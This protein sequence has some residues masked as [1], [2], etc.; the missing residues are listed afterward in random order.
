MCMQEDYLDRHVHLVN[1]RIHV[2]ASMINTVLFPACQAWMSNYIQRHKFA[3]QVQ[4]CLSCAIIL[5]LH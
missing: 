4:L 3:F 5:H 2:H 1:G